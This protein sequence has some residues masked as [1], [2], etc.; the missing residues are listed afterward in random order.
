MAKTIKFNLICDD[1]PVRTIE[2]L[3]NNFSVED[4]LTYYNNK[5]LHRWLR[6]R[7]YSAELDKVT[8]ITCEKP[9][10]II[11]KL[12]AI[13][14][15]ECDSKKVEENIY[16]IEYLDKRKQLCAIYE[17]GS[18]IEQ[19][20]IG[21]YKTGY[22]QLIEGIF[23]N[24]N[25]A[26]KI[27]ANIAEIVNN[28]DWILELNHRNL[29]YN[30]SHCS[31]LAI[32]CLL[33]NEKLRKYYLPIKITDE[34]GTISRD[35]DLAV[36][37]EK[38]KVFKEALYREVNSRFYKSLDVVQSI[39]DKKEMYATICQLISTP[40]FEIDLGDNLRTFSGVTDGFW[41]DLEPRDKKCMIISINKGDFVR[42]TGIINGDLAY[43]DSLNNFVI[44][45]GIDYKC[46]SATLE[47]LYMEV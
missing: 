35:I 9:I 16:M 7:G 22:R 26:A 2:D 33:M 13:F 46:N 42:S 27:K 34:N 1:K 23:E 28:Y 32:M 14:N 11:K 3:Q 15:V 10:K 24:R 25:D 41:K 19:D 5:L 40:Q 36:K 38:D 43:V 39:I 44:V 12:I 20:V 6:V 37:I 8:A 47:F 21:N 4:V 17:K 31:S 18:D 30:L 29:F 45:D